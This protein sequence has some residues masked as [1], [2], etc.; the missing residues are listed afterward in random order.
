[1][2]WEKEEKVNAKFY[3]IMFWIFFRRIV[4]YFIPIRKTI[5][6]QYRVTLN[7]AYWFRDRLHEMKVKP[8]DWRKYE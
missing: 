7:I 4:H 1:M 8:V 3:N 5:P 6:F 2:S